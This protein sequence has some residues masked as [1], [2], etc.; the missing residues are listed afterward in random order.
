MRSLRSFHLLVVLA[1]GMLIL[2]TLRPAVE[3]APP[4]NQFGMIPIT[5]THEIKALDDSPEHR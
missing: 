3:K 2:S 1:L 4:S 5:Q